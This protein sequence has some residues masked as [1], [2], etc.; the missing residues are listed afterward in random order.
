MTKRKAPPEPS[1]DPPEGHPRP[2]YPTDPGGR[3]MFP[4]NRHGDGWRLTT[5][6]D[7]HIEL[8]NQGFNWRIAIVP[9]TFDE[10]TMEPWERAWCYPKQETPLVEV[11]A[12]ALTFDP[13]NGEEPVGWVKE[14][15]T[16]RYA[17][18]H[19]YPRPSN[20]HV[21]YDPDCQFCGDQD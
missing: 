9:I 8:I 1:A 18:Q 10:Y 20:G 13:N 17:C 19:R 14:A 12:I 3:A 21:R 11:V 7:F 15:G 5:K 4:S 16:N 6:G 2:R